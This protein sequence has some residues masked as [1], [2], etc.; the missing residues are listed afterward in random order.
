MRRIITIVVLALCTSLCV[1]ISSAQQTST[2]ATTTTTSVPNLTHYDGALKDAQSA[3]M[4]SKTVGLATTVNPF[5][6]MAGD[7]MFAAPWGGSI[8]PL[9]EIFIFGFENAALGNAT[10]SKI[11]PPNATG[12]PRLLVSNIGSGGGDGVL[13]SDMP[14]TS[15]F[16]AYTTGIGSPQSYPPGSF[17]QVKVMGTING[18]PNQTAATAQVVDTGTQWEESVDFSPITSAPLLAVYSLGGLPVASQIISNPSSY[19]WFWP[20]QGSDWGHSE[21]ED[22][23]IDFFTS[24]FTATTLYINNPVFDKSGL[25]ASDQPIGE[26]VYADG[27]DVQT[28]SLDVTFGG[29]SGESLTASQIPSFTI[30]NETSLVNSGGGPTFFSDLG[31]SGTGYQCCAAW[32]VAGS[33]APTGA[34]NTAAN[35]FTSLG[36]GS[37][38]QI[39]VAV[40]DIS[41][42]NS[43]FVA[44]YTA[45]GGSPGTLIA[46]WSN[47]SSKTT[48][49][50]GGCCGLVTITGITG[51]SLTAGT[52][53][54]LVLGPTNL[55][56]TTSEGWNLN[57]TGATG[58]DLYANSG[59]QNGSGNGCNWNSNGTQTTLGAFD[60][61]GGSGSKSIVKK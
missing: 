37:V 24:W 15:F 2:T 57:S 4:N 47:L 61:L 56:S 12:T 31:E 49:G 32:M 40:G 39:D 48:Y 43:F 59:C 17:F 58:L 9:N 52:S 16:D 11:P 34:S 44:L 3:A 45:S 19:R 35:L 33:G 6:F 60:I 53:Y 8:S 7:G 30:T 22:G 23:F 42:V 5:P 51:V 25:P 21:T 13:V 54:F 29:V 36:S 50:L 20:V 55:S 26:V 18:I 28:T 14:H 38:S 46:Q 41:G 1:S 10:L 27:F